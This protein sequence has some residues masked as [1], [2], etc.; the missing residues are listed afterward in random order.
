MYYLEKDINDTEIYNIYIFI[1]YIQTSYKLK[2]TYVKT[3]NDKDEIKHIKI[4]GV[5]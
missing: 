3:Q 1:N 2:V 4:I 5:I